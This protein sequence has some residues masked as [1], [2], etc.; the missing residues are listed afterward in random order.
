MNLKRAASSTEDVLNNVAKRPGCTL[1]GP[2]ASRWQ[3]GERVGDYGD[4][5]SPLPQY[6]LKPAKRSVL[7]VP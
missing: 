6:Y 4:E 2:E 5:R 1:W 7:T 3:C